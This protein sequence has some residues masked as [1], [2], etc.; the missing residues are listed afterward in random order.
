MKK[1]SRGKVQKKRQKQH[2]SIPHIRMIIQVSERDKERH[3]EREQKK[4][5]KKKEKGERKSTEKTTKYSIQAF[6]I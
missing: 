6:L 1:K 3:R 4:K 2:P 5:K